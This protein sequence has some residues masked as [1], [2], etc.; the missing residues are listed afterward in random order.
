MKESAKTADC[1][2]PTADLHQ[3][4]TIH[5]LLPAHLRDADVKAEFIHSFT[6]DPQRTS[7][8]QLTSIE[9]EEVIYFLKT[10]RNATYAHFATFDHNNRQHRYIL[11]ITHQLG[12]V[13][14]HADKQKMLPDLERLGAWLRKYGH[15]HKPLKNYTEA[16]LPKLVHQLEN[17]L[18]TQTK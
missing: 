8:K 1:G 2:P 6:E 11:S 14:Y 3:I 18:K 5:A 10:G 12:W 16:E 9:A 4:K 7:T 17:L 15:Q 13:K